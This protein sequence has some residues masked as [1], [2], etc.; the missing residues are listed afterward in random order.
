MA[1]KTT[2]Q[3]SAA[4]QVKQFDNLKTLLKNA[5]STTGKDLFQHLQ[6]VFKKL[7]IHYPDQALDKLEEVSYLV[8]NSNTHTMADYLEIE[9]KRNYKEFADSLSGYIS[10]MEKLFEGPKAEEE[11]DEPPEVG[12]VGNVP[13]LLADSKIF[14]W[15]GIGFGEAETYRLMKSMKKLAT[16]SQATNLRFFGKIYGTEKDYYVIE[17]VAEGGEEEPA[18]GEEEKPAD[19]EPKGT[20]VNRLTYWVTDNVLEKW[21]KLPD[22]QTSD[23]KASREIKI[24]FTGELERYVYTNPYFFGKE[25]NYLRAQIARMSHST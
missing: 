13:D 1:Q 21:V 10:K 14:E 12:P 25:K 16:D 7:I 6:E 3:A 15:A 24:T 17:G 18:E 19:F 11:G 8:K 5:K 23:I 22:L 9:D 20:G 4:T 2:M